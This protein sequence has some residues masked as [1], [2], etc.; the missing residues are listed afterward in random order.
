MITE[1]FDREYKREKQIEALKKAEQKQKGKK[2]RKT[3]ADP[4][5]QKEEWIKK[6]EESFWE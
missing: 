4:D 1:M 6:A 3:R 5:S 2:H